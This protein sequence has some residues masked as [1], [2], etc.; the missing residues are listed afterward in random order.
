[1]FDRVRVGGFL[2]VAP[3]V[4]IL[5]VLIVLPLATVIAGAL[6]G[7]WF[8]LVALAGDPAVRAAVRLSMVVALAA[9]V[10]NASFGLL[11]GW[12][13]AKYRFPGKALLITLIDAPL[14][15]SPVIAGLAVVATFGERTPAG[16][17]LAAHGVHVAFA[18]LGIALATTLVTFPY[19][20]RAVI[21]QLSAQGRV[22]EEAAL[23]LG[24]SAWQTFRLVT[25]PVARASFLNGLLICNARAL[26]E[27]GAVS[28]VSGNVRGLT[29]TIPLSFADLYNDARS[30]AAFA[31]AAGLALVAIVL[32]LTARALARHAAAKGLLT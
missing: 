1:M 24:A 4:L 22:L 12:T 11:A 5:G 25:V 20:A 16:G 23:G 19:V 32:A 6:A 29:Q 26:G 27:F 2:A 3:I 28:V 13:I 15:V 31:L 18:P 14:T 17:W 8:A 10:V 21:A 30:E 7:G 9:V